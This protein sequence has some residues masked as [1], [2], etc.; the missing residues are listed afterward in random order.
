M[1]LRTKRMTVALQSESADC[2]LSCMAMLASHYD[3]SIDLGELRDQFGSA[4]GVT[5]ATLMDIA[6]AYGFVPHLL[7]CE[8][9][10]LLQLKSPCILHWDMRHFVVLERLSP[11]RAWII[12][13]AV[14]R[15]RISIEELDQMFTGAVLTIK[16]GL[17]PPKSHKRSHASLRDVIGPTS[18]IRASL[19][20]VLVL[21]AML[22]CV[23]LGSPLLMQ[24]VIDDVITLGDSDLLMVV[25]IG[26]LIATLFQCLLV[27]GRGWALSFAG[28]SFRLQW[29]SAVLF[30]ILTLPYAY[31]QRRSASDVVSRLESVKAIQSTLT[32]SFVE[33][34]L[35]GTFG[36]IALV[37]LGL[38]SLK[39]AFCT[40]ACL[41]AVVLVRSTALHLKRERNEEAI[42]HDIRQQAYALEAVQAIQT[43]KANHAV[44][45][46]HGRWLSHATSHTEADFRI[47]LLES[48]TQALVRLILGLEQCAVIYLGARMVLD[49]HATAGTLV[50]Y[51]MLKEQFLAKA[52]ALTAK[53][54]EF[55]LL[56]THVDRLHDI[57]RETIA[58]PTREAALCIDAP[59]CTDGVLSFQDVWFRYSDGDPWILR[60][61]SFSVRYGES[62]AI[63]G[64]SGG[65]KSTLIKIAAGLLQ[66]T[67]GRI[68]VGVDTEKVAS[69]LQDDHLF[70]GTVA[71]NIS[72]FAE[73]PDVQRLQSC[74]VASQ[75]GDEILH[76]PMGFNT[77]VGEFGSSLSG[78]QK[79]RI[80]LARALYR[81]AELLLLDEATSHLDAANERGVIQ[82]LS[83]MPITRVFVAHRAETIRS[84]QRILRLEGGQVAT[85]ETASI[86]ANQTFGVS[87]T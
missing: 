58:S 32:H 50:G 48:N 21:A 42:H 31:F 34:L 81:Q 2:G 37:I 7:Q 28:A 4:R 29:S 72:L 65:G 75:I 51:M 22:E 52:S 8:L 53:V 83:A 70:A 23:A 80:L 84:A 74:A 15:R 78:G 67:Q 24:T 64:A 60:G 16:P 19:A 76:F 82:E 38:Y 57:S 11:T 77:M 36:S 68:H 87:S 9:G 86:L 27:A 13:P 47:S 6:S 79:Q 69:V 18:G 43:V 55:R 73:T 71:E 39:L 1:I 30:R 26:L 85:G 62:V 61:V 17:P 40:V 63:V 20:K 12:D 10:Q 49:G 66:P 46:V 45:K 35:D 56:R 44:S 41:V 25:G 14:G 59:T 54:M 33:V 3:V 5:A